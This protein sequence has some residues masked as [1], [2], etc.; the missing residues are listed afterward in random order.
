MTL[1][2][3]PVVKEITFFILLRG[4]QIL[5]DLLLNN[6]CPLAPDEVLSSIRIE[7]LGRLNKLHIGIRGRLEVIGVV[8][9]IFC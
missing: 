7:I 6:M 2:F 4:S 3:L 9:K 8:G 1:I 5:G